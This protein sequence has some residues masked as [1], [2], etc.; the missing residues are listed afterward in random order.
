MSRA[1]I[2]VRNDPNH[3]S[4]KKVSAPLLQRLLRNVQIS[5]PEV[6][7]ILISTKTK[8]EGALSTLFWSHSNLRPVRII[9][10]ES[11]LWFRFEAFWRGRRA[12]EWERQC[13]WGSV[14]FL[15]GSGR[16]ESFF[17]LLYVFCAVHFFGLCRSFFSGNCPIP[18]I[19]NIYNGPSVRARQTGFQFNVLH[20]NLI[21]D[22][23]DTNKNTPL[24]PKTKS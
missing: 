12:V 8:P 3:A 9:K 7:I 6:L 18:L 11:G 4:C 2:T 14:Y 1:S 16:T 23:A 19:K 24:S 13:F 21:L 15:S 5:L 10:P 22:L 17:D 20:Q